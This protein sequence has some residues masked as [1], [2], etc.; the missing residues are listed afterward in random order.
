MGFISKMSNVVYASPVTRSVVV[1]PLVFRLLRVIFGRI[2]TVYRCGQSV[3]IHL[4]PSSVSHPFCHFPDIAFPTDDL[5]LRPEKLPSAVC[6][7]LDISQ[8]RGCSPD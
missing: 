8:V 2:L 1:V 6:D 5:V 3:A 4:P 7:A